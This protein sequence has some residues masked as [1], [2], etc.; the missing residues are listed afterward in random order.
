MVYFTEGVRVR[1]LVRS[2]P[3]GKE[4]FAPGDQGVVNKAEVKTLLTVKWDDPTCKRDRV[5]AGHVKPLGAGRAGFAA[6]DRVESTVTFGDGKGGKLLWPGLQGKVT[7][8]TIQPKI[9]VS[10]DRWA[11]DPDQKDGIT[12]LPD[13]VEPVDGDEERGRFVIASPTVL[14]SCPVPQLPAVQRICSRVGIAESIGQASDEGSD[15]PA[16]LDRVDVLLVSKKDGVTTAGLK[17]MWKTNVVK[18]IKI[19]AKLSRK[20][21]VR[22]ICIQGGPT[23]DAEMAMM[24]ELQKASK[25]ALGEDFNLKTEVLSYDQFRTEFM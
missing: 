15:R 23:C 5:D 2:P 10:F 7:Q 22:V 24:P 20:R 14:A 19:V 8:A 3:E 11:G 21:Q 13:Q 12:M 6:G 16:V 4:W 1:C 25:A 18:D 9:V 17:D